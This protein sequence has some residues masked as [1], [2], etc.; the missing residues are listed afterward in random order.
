MF[1]GQ[2]G[3]FGVGCVSVIDNKTH[4][5]RFPKTEAWGLSE[6]D[7]SEVLV[8]NTNR[9]TTEIEKEDAQVTNSR[10][11]RFNNEDKATVVKG[12][13]GNQWLIWICSQASLPLSKGS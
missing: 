6:H 1:G 2:S 11:L 9:S 4:K 8:R 5:R 3:A 13:Y 10:C 12:T 7:P